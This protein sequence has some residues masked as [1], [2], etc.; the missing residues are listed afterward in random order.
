[1]STSSQPH[2][3]RHWIPDKLLPTNTQPNCRWLYLADQPLNAP[4]FGDTRQQC[5]SHPY[6]SGAMAVE[7]SLDWLIDMAQTIPAVAPSAFIFHVSRCG[8]TLLSQLLGLNDRHIVLSEVPLL[9][10]LLRLPHGGQTGADQSE[11]A[12]R[13]ALRLL[14][15]KRTGRET[16]VFIKMD[17][18]HILAYE[19][20][21]QLYP[22]TPFIFLYRSPDAVVRSQRRRR[23]MQAIPGLIPATFFGFAPEQL[24]GMDLDA[25]MAA[26]L[27]R[28]FDTFLTVAGRDTN[29]LLI[30][31]QE[32][33]MAMMDP[34]I[35]FLDLQLTEADYAAMVQRCRYHGKYP[36]QAFS[37]ETIENDAPNYLQPAL[38]LF[39]QVEKIRQSR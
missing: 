1:M 27:E 23:G 11:R 26:V 15:H 38:A 13:A 3:L 4:F 32:N 21:R 16:H 36:D 31:Y 14:S 35:R 29:C 19:T 28:Y 10:T 7:S 6:N 17:S 34:L 30:N 8:S 22:T 20:I 12:F 2:P 18:W 39:R 9:D 33:G 24:A 25:Y 37:E 5:L